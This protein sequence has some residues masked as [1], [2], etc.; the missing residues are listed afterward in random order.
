MVQTVHNYRHDCAAGTYF[1]DGRIC[2][3]CHGRRFPTPAVVHA[4]YRG[5]RAQSAVM[6]ATLAAHR[7]TWRTVDRFLALSEAVAAFLRSLG[8]PADRITVKPNGVPDP[9]PPPADHGEGFLF[10]GRMSAEKGLDLLLDA[11]SRHPDGAL[12]PLRIAGDGEQRDLALTAAAGRDDV[13]YLGRLDP[14]AMRSAV[15]SAAVAVVPSRWDEPF[16]LVV[17]EALANGRPVLGTAT[18][19]IPDVIGDAGWVVPATADGLAAGLATAAAEAP[20]RRPA[21]R[22]RFEANFTE[23]GN[24]KRLLSVYHQVSR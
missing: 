3:D 23:E 18:G 14:A 19:G 2:H 24:L 4:C 21:A 20:A 22:P 15:R 12:G 16:G 8:I 6:A 10:A 1:R 13:M 7:G 5:S 9:G 17:V 11:W